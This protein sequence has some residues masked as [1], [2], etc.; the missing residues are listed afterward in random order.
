MGGMVDRADFEVAGFDVAEAAL[1]VAAGLY[2][3]GRGRRQGKPY[4]G[5][6]LRI[7]YMPSRAASAAIASAL[8]DHVEAISVMA[9]SKCLAMWRRSMTAPTLRAILSW[10]RSG[11][12]FFSVIARILI[13]AVWVNS[14]SS[15]RLR[16]RS[17]ASSGLRQTMR[18]SPGKSVRNDLRHVALDEQRGLQGAA[19]GRERLDRRGAQRGDPVEAG[20]REIGV[21]ARL[22]GHAA[23]ADEHDALQ[24]E[25]RA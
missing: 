19:L 25:A 14:R 2:R 18:R 23:V 10:P 13:S 17:A 11:L 16:A 21:D 8:R 6:E 7:T 24:P 20:G 3:R 5:R 9:R 4:P 12:R 1:G 22:G 15:S